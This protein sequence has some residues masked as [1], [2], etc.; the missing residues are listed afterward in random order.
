MRQDFF[1]FMPTF[2]L[3][4]VG[5]HKPVLHNVDDAARRRFNIVP[6]TRRPATPDRQLEGKLRAEWP[7]IFRWL[8][9]GCLDWQ[10]NGLVGPESVRAATDSYFSDQDMFGQWLEE[11]CDPEPANP[12]KWATTTELFASWADYA[13]AAGE[14]ADGMRSFRD[15]LLRRDIEPFRNMN[16][17]GFR[18]I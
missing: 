9:E 15:M 6:F 8:I 3:L 10:R 2:K 12:H 16:G 7:G 18:G 1:T 14:T 13:K 4:I 11:E 17:R 5:N